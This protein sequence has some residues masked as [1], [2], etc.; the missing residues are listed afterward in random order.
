MEPYYIQNL[1]MGSPSATTRWMLF[2]PQ[3]RF[4]SFAALTSAIGTEGYPKASLRLLTPLCRIV[5][6][7]ERRTGQLFIL[8]RSRLYDELRSQLC[9]IN[10]CCSVVLSQSCTCRCHKAAQA[11]KLHKFCSSENLLFL[12]LLAAINSPRSKVPRGE[13]CCKNL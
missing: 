4:S 3:C 12:C 1:Y 11:R 8:L 10:S 6:S 13:L 2:Y 5:S 7:K 9:E